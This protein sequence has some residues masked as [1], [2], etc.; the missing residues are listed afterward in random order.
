M[1]SLI[2]VG[3]LLAPATPTVQATPGYAYKWLL[4]FDFASSF[5]GQ[6]EIEVGVNENGLVVQPPLYS[7]TVPVRCQ[8]VGAVGL[9]GGVAKFDGG[10]L[11]C[12]LQLQRALE[13]TFAACAQIDPSCALPI[14]AIEQYRSVKIAS[15]F[16]T[17]T[18]GVAPI[19][20]HESVSY[21]LTISTAMHTVQ[22][23]IDPI[24]VVASAAWPVA[25][26]LNALQSHS[27][28]FGCSVAG[29]CGIHFNVAG[30]AQYV[31]SAD[32]PVD[33]LTTPTTFYIG[34]DLAGTTLPGGSVLDN[35]LV[36]PGNG[37]GE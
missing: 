24:G 15:H 34:R 13:A 4:R 9:M 14:N 22:T 30:S 1:I 17:P 11:Q 18:A 31:N 20:S 19:F 28:R 26:A 29:D 6:L 2:V 36:D 21:A 25:P 10:Y 37:F 23:E 12:D 27:A 16:L 3:L 7:Q 8:R 5:D 35:L 33:F 32:A